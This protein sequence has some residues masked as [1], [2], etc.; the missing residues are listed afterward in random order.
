M[1]QWVRGH[2]AD[3]PHR[4]DEQLPSVPRN[5][6]FDT[7]LIEDCLKVVISC[8]RPRGD[9]AQDPAEEDHFLEIVQ[10]TH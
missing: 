8:P 6:V 10:S 5:W 1:H 9:V 3:P 4:K 2:T 7:L